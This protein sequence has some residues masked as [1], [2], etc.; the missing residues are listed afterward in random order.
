MRL[1][2][3]TSFF[4]DTET[5]FDIAAGDEVDA[6]G[7]LAITLGKNYQ[8]EAVYLILMFRALCEQQCGPGG[9]A[10]VERSILAG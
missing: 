3:N 5:V 2:F 8:A 10:A 7:T 4:E 9:A 6:A 1:I